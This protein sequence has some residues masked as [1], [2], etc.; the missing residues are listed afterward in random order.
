[1]APVRVYPLEVRPVRARGGGQRHGVQRRVI[2]PPRVLFHLLR[3]ADRVRA[4]VTIYILLPRTPRHGVRLD[5][6]RIVG[7]IANERLPRLPE[8]VPA[9]GPIDAR[10]ALLLERERI[11]ER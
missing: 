10:R 11:G 8:L 2:A 5:G 9:A 4:F 1:M 6:V 3:E 7:G